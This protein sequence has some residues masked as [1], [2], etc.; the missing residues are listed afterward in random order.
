MDYDDND[1]QCQ[2]FQIVGEDSNKLPTSLQLLPSPKFDFDEHLHIH[3][4]FDSLVETEVV[5]GIQGNSWMEDYTPVRSEIEFSTTADDTCSISRPKN[6]WS[7]ATSSESVEMLLKSVGGEE[8]IDQKVSIK[9]ADAV[10][11]LN[12]VNCQTDTCSRQSDS[13]SETADILHTDTPLPPNNCG[14]INRYQL[15]VE[16]GSLE[17]SQPDLSSLETK[18]IVS[19]GHAFVSSSVPGQALSGVVQNDDPLPKV[20]IKRTTDDSIAGDVSGEKSDFITSRSTADSLSDKV[21][22]EHSEMEICA[23][24]DLLAD[25]IQKKTNQIGG[26]NVSYQISER[27]G[28][29]SDPSSAEGFAF[30]EPNMD[31]SLLDENCRG[32]EFTEKATCFRE[33]QPDCPLPMD[34]IVEHQKVPSRRLSA[35]VV[36]QPDEKEVE[37]PGIKVMRSITTAQLSR[38]SGHPV[39]VDVSAKAMAQDEPDVQQIQPEDTLVIDE[40]I[41]KKEA[42]VSQLTALLPIQPNEK[43][44]E[45]SGSAPLE[46]NKDTGVVRESDDLVVFDSSSVENMT[47]DESDAALATV[48][49]N[50]HSLEN[51]T[52][53]HPSQLESTPPKDMDAEQKE[54]EICGSTILMTKKDS[55]ILIESDDAVAM[56]SSSAKDMTQDE[57]DVD[58]SQSGDPSPIDVIVEQKEATMPYLHALNQPDVKDVE[59][60][61][62]PILK[63]GTDSHESRET[64]VPPVAM[65]SLSANQ[66]DEKDVE[67]SGSAVLKS[68]TDAHASR[69]TDVPSAVMDS[70]SAKDVTQNEPV[71]TLATVDINV[72]HSQL[73]DI[74]PLDVVELKEESATRLPAPVL[75]QPDEE[76]METPGST[77]IKSNDGALVSRDLDQSVLN[78]S[79]DNDTTQDEPVEV[80][81]VGLQLGG[82]FVTPASSK[83]N[84]DSTSG[85]FSQEKTIL[86]TPVETASHDEGH[87]LPMDRTTLT[88]PVETV[89]HDERHAMLIDKPSGDNQYKQPSCV[90]LGPDDNYHPLT[91]V[92]QTEGNVVSGTNSSFDSGILSILNAKSEMWKSGTTKSVTSNQGSDSPPV[93]G[94][95][96]HSHGEMGPESDGQRSD[97]TDSIPAEQVMD[98]KVKSCSHDSME[99]KTSED[100]R[101]FTF[102][103]GSIADFSERDS[104]NKWKP[105]SD[106]QSSE[107]PQLNTWISKENSQ[108]SDLELEIPRHSAITKS[109][110]EDNTKNVSDSSTMDRV[111]I[112]P[113]KVSKETPVRKKSAGSDGILSST[114]KSVGTVNQNA[115]LEETPVRKKSARS[116][117]IL[118]STP[119]SVGTA[120]QNAKLEEMQHYSSTNSSAKDSFPPVLDSNTSVSSM[121]LFNQPFTDL[122][123]VQLRAQIFVYG[124]LMQ[125]NPPDEAC[126]ISAFGEADGGRSIWEGVWRLSVERYQIPKS[127]F[128]FETPSNSDSVIRVSEQATRSSYLQSKPL[129]IPGGSGSLVASSATNSTMPSTPLWSVSTLDEL[130]SS[131]PRVMQLEFNQEPSSSYSHQ[132]SQMRQYRGNSSPWLSQS[133]RPAP[134]LGSSQNSTLD[135][136]AHYST[137][138]LVGTVEV[139]PARVSPTFLGNPDPTSVSAAPLGQLESQRK[140]TPRKNRSTSTVQKSR[141]RT[142]GL[143]AHEVLNSNIL[144]SELRLDPTSATATSHIIAPIDHQII[145]SSDTGQRAIFSDETFTKIE[146]ARLQAEDAASFAASAVRHSQ[147]V[148]RQLATQKNTGII[149]EADGK[150][151]SAAVAVAAAANVAKA[152]AAAA[153]VASNAALLAKLMADE[154][155]NSARTGNLT[156]ISDSGPSDVGKGLATLTP[157]SILKGK[158]EIHGTG[159]IISAARE[160]SRRRVEA[161]CAA[162]IRAENLD[163]LMRAAELAAEAVSQAGTIIAMGEPLPFTLSDLVEAGPEGHWKVHHTSTSQLDKANS[164]HKE[165]NVGSHCAMNCAISFEELNEQPSSSNRTQKPTDDCG[166]ISSNEHPVPREEYYEGNGSGHVSTVPADGDKQD[167]SSSNNK[168]TSIQKGCLVEV[169][170][171]CGD[172]KGT[173]F[174]ARVLDVKDGKSYVCYDNLVSNEGPGPLKEL[175]FH[176]G[177]ADKAPRIRLA[178]PITAAKYEGPRKRRREAI[179][180]VGDHVD[181]WISNGWREGVVTE[182]S[183]GDDTKFTV[184]FL[185]GDDSSTVRASDLRPSL[186][187]VDGHWIEWCPARKNILQPEGST[188]VGKRQKLSVLADSIE[189][190]VDVKGPSKVSTNNSTEDSRKPEESRPLNLSAKERTFSVGKNA[191]EE[192]THDALKV[193]QTGLQKEGSGLAIGVP[194]PGKKRKFMDVSKHYVEDKKDKTREGNASVKVAKYLMPQS[195]RV[196]RNTSKVDSKGKS[197]ITSKSVGLKP[198]KSQSV[199]IRSTADRDKSSSRASSNSADSAHGVASNAKVAFGSE[200]NNLGKKSRLEVG[201][202]TNLGA[203]ENQHVE[204]Q[205]S[206]PSFPAS[207]KKPALPV[208]AD[209][210]VNLGATENPRVETSLKFVPVFPSSKKKSASTVEA[211]SRVKGKLALA[212]DKPTRSGDGSESMGPT[213]SDTPEPRRSSRRIQPTSRLLEGLQSS[214]V[215]SKI[216]AFPH[217]KGN[218]PQNRGGASSKVNAHV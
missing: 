1:F 51:S 69:E 175:V 173:W 180:A 212:L 161:A 181:A 67:I 127:P 47:Q 103:V 19:P 168:E 62:S 166:I 209:S 114:P 122:Q 205:K 141:K 183:Q 176:E 100:T 60:S 41:N 148:W 131:K 159:S 177:G 208:E 50:L 164:I 8:M 48:D 137:V 170:S 156:R 132:P 185:D 201:S 20:S 86:I 215:I 29:G 197:A 214:L 79:P 49:V 54:G 123:Q 152:A 112:S 37:N 94:H 149:S 195:S 128:G 3:P 84:V 42:T 38:E 178:H 109:I 35:M 81:S 82:N 182:K 179:W 91:G 210:R 27:L 45:I 44:V 134:W 184:H 187:W 53:V 190:E 32:L 217:E 98:G 158:D 64:D 211:D 147:D 105:F 194:K 4:R 193:R 59:I 18:L 93:I 80:T 144:V 97:P 36:I 139:T 143:P 153:K 189:S 30:S 169:K 142:N 7:E 21:M 56:D 151:A 28:V 14:G 102:E 163:A 191:G 87:A 85:G 120:N 6:I 76:V 31:S 11:S 68:S 218:K 110:E 150:L 92:A 126:M 133:P 65:D 188:P 155:L 186:V 10:V 22:E 165:G 52:D 146:Q 121:A 66:H 111:V 199:Q 2:N 55:Q 96:G 83:E 204:S 46:N 78:I 39:V 88:T 157:L 130:H 107:L 140:L 154:A 57:P 172:L 125:G 63:S 162:T 216:P 101:S 70:L 34:A 124:S 171:D 40:V 5:L 77:N 206:V 119:K 89:S 192:N 71:I 15:V 203:T 138:P 17:P 43:Q 73:E 99:C 104:G 113:A 198:A 207:R 196:L 108:E 200:Q 95:S 135:P 26:S 75:I 74:L 13:N 58:Q 167:H 174:S 115:K 25:S 16:E 145:N 118:S 9:E 160:T 117:G 90:N 106:I 136:V 72:H 202:H 23:R 116:D 61:G 12:D 33:S 213:V 24:S 129:S